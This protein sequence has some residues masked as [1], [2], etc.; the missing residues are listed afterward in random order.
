MSVEMKILNFQLYVSKR[1][2]QI[3]KRLAT[4]EVTIEE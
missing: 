4:E 2:R 3:N 1:I